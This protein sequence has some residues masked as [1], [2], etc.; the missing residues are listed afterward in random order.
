MGGR[1]AR[2]DHP[3]RRTSRIS[4]TY[5]VIGL[6]PSDFG[7]FHVRETLLAVMSLASRGPSGASGAAVDRD[8]L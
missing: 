5:P 8:V 6:P 2:G 7:G 1:V 4:S 3:T